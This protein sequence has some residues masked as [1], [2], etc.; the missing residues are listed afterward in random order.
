LIG[1][2]D[3]GGREGCGEGARR[4]IGDDGGGDDDDSM[5]DAETD[6]DDDS[7]NGLSEVDRRGFSRK[8]NFSERIHLSVD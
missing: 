6:R 1:S 4:E 2:I 3:V 8:R 5:G 7:M